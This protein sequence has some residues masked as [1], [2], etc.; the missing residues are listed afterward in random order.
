MP[1]IIMCGFPASGKTKRANEIK[2]YIEQNSG[3]T[4]NIIG[5]HSMGVNRNT[6]YEGTCVSYN[7]ISYPAFFFYID[8]Y[9][10]RHAN[11]LSIMRR[12]SRVETS[13]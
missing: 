11:F 5:D 1:L 12:S 7:I 2:Q 3:K 8:I 10:L 9:I 13:T 6:V 4:V